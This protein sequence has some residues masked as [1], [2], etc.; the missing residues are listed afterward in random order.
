M[1]FADPLRVHGPPVKNLCLRGYR[2]PQKAETH[3]SNHEIFHNLFS[4]I[5]FSVKREKR[6]YQDNY[7][8]A[9]QGQP[10]TCR[11]GKQFYQVSFAS[12]LPFGL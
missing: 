2:E 7:D 5:F 12:G 11:Q 10:C 6:Q 3:F 8:V 1:N 4:S 9:G